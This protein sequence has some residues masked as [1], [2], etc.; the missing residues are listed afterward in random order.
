MI[1]FAMLNILACIAWALTWHWRIK[2]FWI[3]PPGPRPRIAQAMPRL[4]LIIPARNE[5]RR[6]PALLSAL[7][8]IAGDFEILVA[9]DASSDNTLG[10]A[11]RAARLDPRIRAFSAPEKPPA[12]IGKPWALH[13]AAKQ[14]VGE[15]LVFMD[16]DVTPGAE[17]LEH[18]A[19]IMAGQ[20][21]DALSLIP[22]MRTPSAPAACLLAC[23]AAGRA[24]FLSPARPGRK[25]GIAQG[26]FFAIRRAAYDAVGGHAA[27]AGCVVEDIALGRLLEEKGFRVLTLAAQDLLQSLAYST[28][29]EAWVEM[30][31]HIY[32]AL[33]FSRRNALLL[34][35]GIGFLAVYPPI[36]LVAALAWGVFH[37]SS[38]ALAVIGSA[39]AAALAAY[40]VLARV[41]RQ[42]GLQAI[43]IPA[44]PF[45]FLVSAGMLAGSVLAYTRG[46]VAWKDR[47]YPAR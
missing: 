8:G 40:C 18:A 19:A 20:R 30:Q 43:A 44:A 23:L 32:P 4:S 1:L 39:L 14:A 42:E 27:V 46:R 7:R 28:F 15:L 21:L 12:W 16:A 24:I 35:L 17:L 5:E 31:K 38:A 45:A 33:G 10:C 13:H 22:A 41:I 37:P 11:V 34:A 2:P 25:G 3:V 26:A 36:A 9:D 47:H 29:R 6:L